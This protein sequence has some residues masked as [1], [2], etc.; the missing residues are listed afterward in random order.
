MAYPVTQTDSHAITVLY[1]EGHSQHEIFKKFKECFRVR[2]TEIQYKTK[3]LSPS[4]IE[5]DTSFKQN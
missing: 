3:E 4:E 1:Q 5:M 2:K